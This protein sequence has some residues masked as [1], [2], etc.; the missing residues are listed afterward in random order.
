MSKVCL[1]EL[2]RAKNTSERAM[3]VLAH[4]CLLGL[5]KLLQ[6][7]HHQNGVATE[8]ATRHADVTDYVLPNIV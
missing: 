2:G 6:I 8:Y 3:P 5:H 1:F 4:S 7:S